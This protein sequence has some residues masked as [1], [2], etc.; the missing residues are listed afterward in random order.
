MSQNSNCW[1]K[2]RRSVS[3]VRWYLAI[4]PRSS[5]STLS[6][7]L[8]AGISSSIGTRSGGSEI[9]R[10]RP[11]TIRVSF[12]SS[13]MLSLV[14][15]LAR[16][17][18]R[19]FFCRSRSWVLNCA[20]SWS[21]SACAYQTSRLVIPAKLR[22]ACRYWAAAA[23]TISRRCLAGNWFSRPATSRLAASRLT[24]H[25]QGP[26]RV[27]SKSL[28]SNIR[29]RSADPKRPKLD[30]CASPHAC[31]AIPEIGV[32]ARSLAIGRAAPR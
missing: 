8:S 10:G 29:R 25:S 9:M 16:P 22:M 20:R 4:R 7:S 27:S 11:S 1:S 30:R 24:S 23:M 14:R 31:T 17:L 26:G 18:S 28:T 12:P 3:S 15:A 13:C 6:L 2:Y 21:M 5:S 32:V 19:T